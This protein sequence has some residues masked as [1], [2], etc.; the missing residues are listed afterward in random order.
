MTYYVVAPYSDS[1]INC[2]VSC[3][4]SI[5]LSTNQVNFTETFHFSVKNIDEKWEINKKYFGFRGIYVFTNKING[6]QYVGSSKN[7]G[8]R[9]KDYFIISYL[10]DQSLRGSSICKA[11]LKYGYNNFTLSV[12]VLGPS[13]ENL[14][15]YSKENQPDYIELEQYL[16][17]NY[18]FIY[19]INR[20]ASSAAYK[21]STNKV[22]VGEKNPSHRKTGDKSHAWLNVHSEQN[23]R[24]Y[25]RSKARGTYKFYVYSDNFTLR[26]APYKFESASKLAVF[27]NSN[28]NFGT[29][30]AK[31]IV[32]IGVVGIRYTSYIITITLIEPS[33]LELSF[34]P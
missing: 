20:T 23:N 11:L 14:E 16:L 13:I 25:A 34:P 5:I 1:F 19:N 2:A 33:I 3:S 24:R 30:L 17:D 8:V 7:L 31:L 9:L 32:S 21:R 18:T 29:N 6:K 12:K 4:Y 26:A 28:K 10:M 22:N 27:F 15:N